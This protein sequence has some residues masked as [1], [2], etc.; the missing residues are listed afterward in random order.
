MESDGIYQEQV[1]QD[2]FSSIPRKHILQITN[3]G[4]HEWKV[5]PG[6]PDTGGQNVYVNEFT[7]AL[8]NLGYRVTIV[9]RGGYPDPI[10]GQVRRGVV[11]HPT[12]NAR[13]MYVEDGH[14]EFVRKEDMDEHLPALADDLWNK[15]EKEDDHYDLIISH[16]WDAGKLGNLLNQKNQQPVTHLWVPHSLGALKKTN[17]PPSTWEDLRVD[18]RIS[19]EKQL[20]VEVDGCVATSSKIRETLTDA[21]RVKVDYF[22]PPGVD[23]L[24]FHPRPNDELKPIWKWLAQHSPL[25]ARELRQRLWI[26]EVSRTD[27]TKRKDIL[28]KAFAQ[29]KKEIPEA[30]LMVAID[31]H[32]EELYKKLTGLIDE[33][34]LKDDV[35]ILGSVWDQLPLLYNVADV[36]CTPSI[37]EGFGMSAQEAAAT[38]TPVVASNL[39]PFVQEYL[40]GDMPYCQHKAVN[41]DQVELCYG[42]AGVVVPKDFVE[43]FAAALAELLR[44]KL[45]R[46]LMGY[47][48]LNITIPHFTWGRMVSNLLEKL[49]LGSEETSKN[50]TDQQKQKE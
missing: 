12:G 37:M 35:I 14:Q 43:G 41:G 15:L 27:D 24:R 33:L 49:G 38:A 28:I 8:I 4:T 23:D 44:S 22:L 47:H 39:V 26:M 10:N 20:L 16:Y 13:I 45:L 46:H 5:R 36:Y 31:K 50:N 19:H 11:Y 2:Q 6:L 40:L 17:M 1:F 3:H 32:T 18:E 34:G 42:T 9:N 30:M 7:E 48:G 25:S 29:V 21:Y